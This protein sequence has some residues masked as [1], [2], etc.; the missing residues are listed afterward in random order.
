MR[1]VTI[2]AV[3]YRFE[4]N[5]LLFRRGAAHRLTV[6]PR[7][8]RIAELTAP[9]FFRAIELRSAD[10]LNSEHTEIVVQPVE[11]KV[12]YFVAPR[13]GY[14]A[15][16]YAGHDWAGMTG[17]INRSPSCSTRS[18]TAASNWPRLGNSIDKHAAMHRKTI[19]RTTIA[20]ATTIALAACGLGLSWVKEGAKEGDFQK[21]YI[22]CW[23]Q[24]KHAYELNNC[25]RQ[26]GWRAIPKGNS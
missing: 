26:R 19:G 4:P 23:Q 20:F 21:D 6:V 12:L 3:E 1:P 18:R 7:G 5:H 9:K 17:D 8:P 24:I 14:F 15:M 11:Q 2:V 13:A 10:A 25:L 22:A 16:W